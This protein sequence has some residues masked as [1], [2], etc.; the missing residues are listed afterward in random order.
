MT[1]ASGYY[2]SKCEVTLHK[3]RF[4]V[5]LSE[6]VLVNGEEE[7]RK[8]LEN[9]KTAYNSRNFFKATWHENQMSI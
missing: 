5:E 9:N 2:E 7:K 4:I 3:E 6:S 1:V 8:L